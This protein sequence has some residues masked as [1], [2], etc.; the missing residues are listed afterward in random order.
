[1]NSK[2]LIHSIMRQTTVLIA[3]LSTAFGIRAPLSH[4]ADQV[5]LNL[6]NEI[7]AQGVAR[8][9]VADMFGLALRSYQK[10][11][12][13][14]TES[15]SAPN[16]TLWEAL[17]EFLRENGSSTRQRIF[18][19]FKHDGLLEVGA[20]L[21]D[22]VHSG[23]IHVTGKGDSAIYGVLSDTEQQRLAQQSDLESMTSMIW[24][25]VYRRSQSIEEL[26]GA[27]ASDQQSLV[28]QAVQTLLAE[29]RLK[30]DETHSPGLLSANTFLVPVGTEQGWEAAVFDHFQT[31]AKAIAAKARCGKTVSSHRDTIGGATLSFDLTPDHPYADEV[32]GLLAKIRKDVNELWGKV[33]SYNQKCP[34]P[35]SK[36]TRVFFYFGQ[37][38]E[39]FNEENEH[40]PS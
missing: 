3:Q 30:L 13:R 18:E 25:S 27:F 11:V 40:E 9:V 15:A 24:L 22:L 6:A 39:T 14:L 33:S 34:I 5:F 1:M 4:I 2:L 20:V 12:Q 36:R 8:K 16:R 35:D 23:L 38:V 37:N 31:V 26:I 21:N 32:L 19:R 7:E 28:R 17:L 10:K 29:G